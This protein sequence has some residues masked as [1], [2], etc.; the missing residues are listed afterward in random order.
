LTTFRITTRIVAALGAA[1]AALTVAGVEGEAGAAPAS[2]EWTHNS[3]K[4]TMT[5]SDATPAVGDT[6]TLATAFQRKLTF[7]DI[8]NY[9]ALID[10]CLEYVDGSGKWEGRPVSPSRVQIEAAPA[11]QQAFVRVESTGGSAWQVWGVGG[12]WG[13]ART[14]SMDFYVTRGCA[15]GKA[16]P[17]T[18]HYGGH[19]GSGIYNDPSRGPEITVAVPPT[20]PGDGGT[21]PGDGDGDGDGGTSDNGGASGSL[22]TGSLGNLFG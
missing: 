5:V 16:M 9:K 12:S 1:A 3:S 14:I 4:F 19:L 7:E 10:G 17:T 2:T 15:T 13:T 22:D 8:Y 6:I 18:M 20:D 21:N 11:G